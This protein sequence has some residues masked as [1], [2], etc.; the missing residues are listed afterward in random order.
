MSTNADVVIRAEGLGKR[1]II[2]HQAQRE[3]YVALRDVIAQAARN[4]FTKAGSPFGSRGL[5]GTTT[6]EFWALK[7]V[8]FEVRRGEVMGI[9]G[10]NGAGKR[11]L[12][13]VLSRIAEPTEGRVTIKGR[14]SSLLEVGTGFHPELSGREN[15]YLNGAILGMTRSEIKRKFDEIVDFAEIE[16]FL[17][18]PVKRYSSGMYVRL[19]FAVAAHLEPEILI[20][21]EV[22][23]VGDAEFQ[24]KCLGKMSEVAGGGRTVL[25][26]SHNMD[27]VRRLCVSGLLL[28]S[29][30]VEF[31]GKTEECIERYVSQLA[32]LEASHTI[33]FAKQS[34]KRPHLLRIEMFDAQNGPLPRPTTWGFV[35]FRIHFHSPSQVKNASIVLYIS[36]MS[37][38]L[39][40]MCSTT[41]DSGISLEYRPG[42]NYVDCDIS[43]LMLS[44]GSFIV[45]AGLFVPNIEWFDN[46]PLAAAFEV[47]GRDIFDSGLAPSANRY[48]IPMPHAW[49]LPGNQAAAHREPPEGA[50]QQETLNLV[51]R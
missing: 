41:P 23:A 20:V 50:P 26:V 30:V 31:A 8:S 21:D 2:G 4:V 12:L 5:S 9:I 16:K 15:I 24:K 33:E 45:G 28:S 25:F 38:V 46:Q 3:P 22:L 11:T 18:T 7:N 32:N 13:K 35:R 6:E 27:A 51:S 43:Q 39:L 34:P 48:L 14:V 37:G 47:Q 44:A 40:T 1:Y 42:D 29:G 17:D 10:R 19:A 49:R 36:T